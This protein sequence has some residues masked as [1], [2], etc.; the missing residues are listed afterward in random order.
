[1]VSSSKFRIGIFCIN[2]LKSFSSIPYYIFKTLS[3]M[4]DVEVVLFPR[5]RG[6]HPP[7]L[8]RLMKRLKKFITN[9]AYLWE[10]N[11]ERC[12]FISKQLDLFSQNY[13]VDAILLFGSENCAYSETHTPLFCYADSIF[14]ARFD[15][16]PDQLRRIVDK[17][18]IQEGIHVQQLG[19]NKLNKLFISTRWAIE[20]ASSL[21]KYKNIENKYE[22]VYIGANLP[23][24]PDI[25]EV[26]NTKR[27]YDFVWVGRNWKRKNGEFAIDVVSK[28]RDCGIDSKL[29]II[30]PVYPNCLFSWVKLYGS[31]SY[32][33]PKD[34]SVLSQAYDSSIGHLLPSRA[35][36]SPISICEAFSFA[37]PVIA[38]KL[39]G[40]PE[41]VEDGKTGLLLDLTCPKDWAEKIRHA[42]DHGLF[43][44]MNEA[45]RNKYISCLNWNVVC[46]KMIKS[47]K[48]ECNKSSF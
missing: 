46:Q 3:A 11:P 23:I 14:G 35:D 21:F 22:V 26:G 34:L 32:E 37:R 8:K 39:F 41:I 33:D 45:C 13:S 36:I 7:I 30:G 12:K 47:M 25:K 9:R 28:L 43:S 24:I 19:I 6:Y 18:S 38:T 27:R 15:I 1:M 29:H 40:I 20:R 10:K 5:S 17:D 2:D 42:I 4:P 31:L 16:Y 48:D 44:Q